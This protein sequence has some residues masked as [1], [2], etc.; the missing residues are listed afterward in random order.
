MCKDNQNMEVE[1]IL[2]IETLFSIKRHKESD[3]E[4][5]LVECEAL[6]QPSYHDIKSMV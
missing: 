3:N 1:E 6:K 4:E 2:D 5:K